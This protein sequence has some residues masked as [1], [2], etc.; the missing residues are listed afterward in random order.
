MKI[1][2]KNFKSFSDDHELSL[3][4]FNVIIGKNNAGKS[5]L[6]DLIY[7]Y[8]LLKNRG[9]D[10][11][12]LINAS[13]ETIIHLT[14]AW[15]IDNLQNA[16]Q[17][18]QPKNSDLEEGELIKLHDEESKARN[19]YGT[20]IFDPLQYWNRKEYSHNS[21]DYIFGISNT[22]LYWSYSSQ[23]INSMTGNMSPFFNDKNYISM[24]YKIFPS[25]ITNTEYKL[26]EESK[27]RQSGFRQYIGDTMAKKEGLL[28]HRNLIS[29]DC[30]HTEDLLYK[31]EYSD[32]RGKEW[33]GDVSYVTRIT[34]DKFFKQRLKD[35][36]FYLTDLIKL[37]CFDEDIKSAITTALEQTAYNEA[38]TMPRSSKDGSNSDDPLDSI[39]FVHDNTLTLLRATKSENLFID[40]SPMITSEQCK[41]IIDTLKKN[42]HCYN[43]PM[44]VSKECISCEICRYNVECINNPINFSINEY[45]YEMNSI[46]NGLKEEL[47]K[48]NNAQLILA[49]EFSGMK[50]DKQAPSFLDG[51]HMAKQRKTP[52]LLSSFGSHD[53]TMNK[54]YPS[55]TQTINVA[56]DRLKEV[57]FKEKLQQIDSYGVNPAF[58]EY[59]KMEH[60]NEKY[61]SRLLEN[62]YFLPK[63]ISKDDFS[64][65]FQQDILFSKS[66]FV[67]P[68]FGHNPAISTLVLLSL[69]PKTAIERFVYLTPDI[70]PRY[71]IFSDILFNKNISDA[72]KRML[73][74]EVFIDNY[75]KLSFTKKNYQKEFSKYM[76]N[77][78]ESAK[79]FRDAVLETTVSGSDSPQRSFVNRYANE[80]KNNDPIGK[81][82]SAHLVGFFYNSSVGNWKKSFSV[83]A[84]KGTGYKRKAIITTP[85]PSPYMRSIYG[86]NLKESTETSNNHKKNFL[87]QFI[88]SFDLEKIHIDIHNRPEDQPPVVDYGSINNWRPDH[89]LSVTLGPEFEMPTPENN[90]HYRYSD[91]I[92][93]KATHGKKVYYKGKKSN[94]FP[95]TAGPLFHIDSSFGWDLLEHGKE[96]DNI[97]NL[98]KEAF[99]SRRENLLNALGFLQDVKM[100]EIFDLIDISALKE[101]GDIDINPNLG[102]DIIPVEKFKK[103][104][105]ADSYNIPYSSLSILAV[106]SRMVRDILK[107]F[108]F[109]A[110]TENKDPLDLI[111]KIRNSSGKAK[112]KLEKTAAARKKLKAND[113][114]S[115]RI[116]PA[117]RKKVA[118][119]YK[120]RQKDVDHQAQVILMFILMKLM[121]RF[122]K[123]AYSLIHHDYLK[124]LREL[125]INIGPKSL[126]QNDKYDVEIIN[127]VVWKPYR[128]GVKKNNSNSASFDEIKTFL[129]RDFHDKISNE[130]KV[131]NRKN[132]SGDDDD[133]SMVSAVIHRINESLKAIGTGLTFNICPIFSKEV[134]YINDTEKHSRAHFT[135]N[136]KMFVSSK[137]V[138]SPLE[139]AGEGISA[140]ISILARIH[141]SRHNKNWE[142][143]INTKF[144]DD[145]PYT[146]SIIREP[147][148]HLHPNLIAKLIDHLFAKSDQI[149][150]YSS[151]KKWAII[152]RRIFILETHSEV[153]LRQTQA[154]IKKH[155][156]KNKNLE[157]VVKVCYVDQKSAK[158]DFVDK[159]GKTQKRT[160]EKSSIKDLKLKN[161]GFFDRN[162]PKGFFDIN[163]NL[164]A[165]LWKEDYKPK[166]KVK[167]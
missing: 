24:S 99:K 39:E 122:E 125:R 79:L 63:D 121:N 12:P 161:N 131:S 26:N 138:E 148:N 113:F 65:Q 108:N 107:D 77:D 47:K 165:D 163:T 164:I 61:L 5:S 116:S 86:H 6:S 151:D 167:K 25:D 96:G 50:F 87:N 90:I 15:K 130:M 158:E 49:P 56:V 123:T 76:K 92:E 89:K 85:T 45:I 32:S 7:Y 156:S 124:Q 43:N 29:C 145:K 80:W 95:P 94:H 16:N 18:Q 75:K 100:D 97:E 41:R 111:D 120:I 140:L 102:K 147:E 51:L 58:N 62:E 142:V 34:H 66:T 42:V 84:K 46:K 17:S 112:E 67:S 152:K 114:Y 33:K 129:G 105:N 74:G 139:Q 14:T 104:L 37:D 11:H 136:F 82:Y 153:V 10:Q 57:V 157:S 72:D 53:Y 1:G 109:S 31:E 155:S 60:D 35:K 141:A 146:V 98:T 40:N 149:F 81:N 134:E 132:F 93:I 36:K 20:S 117:V 133:H 54:K 4:S 19:L 118:K 69:V 88:P 68:Y 91:N 70:Y 106:H 144:Y 3:G 150:D 30:N 23:Q 143:A 83:G 64:Y 162:I 28:V 135:G 13:A 52:T 27:K 101:G 160:L 44:D 115:P 48:Y 119:K 127:P 166:K 55:A 128:K 59:A 2:F 159:D 137:T 8:L 38:P 9:I 21:K 103:L 73:F 110:Q 126:S 71:H 22:Q 78:S 154:S